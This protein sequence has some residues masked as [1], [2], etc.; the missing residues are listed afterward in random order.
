MQYKVKTKEDQ[1]FD[2]KNKFKTKGIKSGILTESTDGMYRFEGKK[3]GDSNTLIALLKKKEVESIFGSLSS[4]TKI[5]E[6]EPEKPKVPK[7][8]KG[9]KGSKAPKAPKAPEEV[10]EGE[11]PKALEDENP[12]LGSPEEDDEEEYSDENPKTDATEPEPDKKKP[13]RPPK[14][15]K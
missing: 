4:L 2:F 6:V 7:A 9:S 8:P 12:D 15:D 11:A 3:R 14:A 13:G 1:G 5:V 10:D